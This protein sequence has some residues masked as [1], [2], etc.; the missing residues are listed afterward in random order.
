MGKSR[1]NRKGKK[2]SARKEARQEVRKEAESKVMKT[3]IEHHHNHNKNSIKQKNKILDFYDKN[4]K[5]LLLIPII[6]FVLALGQ[7]GFQI[8]QTGSFID[9]DISLKGGVS[10]TVP[11]TQAVD[12]ILMQNALSEKGFETNVRNIGS[13]GK[14]VGF[15]VESGID[16]NDKELSDKLIAAINE[17]SPVGDDYSMEGVGA[18]IGSSFF[19]QAMIALLFSFIIMAIIVGINFRTFVPSAAVILAA[20]ADIVITVAI[21]NLLGIKFSTAG[22]AALLMLIGYSVDTDILLTTRVIKRREGTVFERV[23]SAMKTGMLMNFTTLVAITIGLIISSS[24]VIKQ[25]MMILFIGLLVDQV[26]TW[27]Q[28]VGI[29]R[30]Y[31][32]KKKQ[33]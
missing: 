16:F 27:I 21:A 8:A 29:L 33:E 6:M 9:K 3:K 4:Y 28:N 2:N 12:T 18:S 1:K 32:D 26:S 7:I 31:M 10:I 30:I 20:V 5:I 22:I 13:S 23:L 15:L 25:I 24:E 11:T 19:K 14:T 17:I